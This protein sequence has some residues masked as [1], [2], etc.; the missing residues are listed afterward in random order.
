MGINSNAVLAFSA[1]GKH[2]QTI[3][4]RATEVFKRQ[5][6][7]FLFRNIQVGNRPLEHLRG[8]GDGL[9]QGGMGM[10]GEADVGGIRAHFYGV[11]DFGDEFAG[12]GADDAG[13]DDAFGFVVE[14][15]LGDALAAAEA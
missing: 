14:D 1:S 8:K 11:G 3:S 6:L 12:V 4:R 15:Q 9:G 5:T 2:F 7:L 10:D 13:A